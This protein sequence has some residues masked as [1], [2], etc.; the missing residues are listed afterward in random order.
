MS[1]PIE[2]DFAQIRMGNA[3]D[4]EV[5][6]VICDLT[7][8][9]I[10]E[11][12]ETSTRYRR[13]CATPN[14]PAMRRSRVQGTFWDVTGTGISNT[15]QIPTL[16]AA[17][18]VR[19]NYEIIGYRDDGT[20]EGAEI[21]T[22]AGEAILTARNYSVDREGETSMEVTLEGQDALVYTAAA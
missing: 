12:A 15:V 6:T 11:G 1:V 22:W 4:P 9:S 14:K 3:A 16:K 8:V 7:S 2:I 10:N 19:K 18:G 13:D 17:L 20:D 5:F 21:G